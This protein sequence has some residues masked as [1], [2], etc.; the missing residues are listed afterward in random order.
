MADNKKRSLKGRNTAKSFRNIDNQLRRKIED[1]IT[2]K[3]L[4]EVA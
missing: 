4:T 1:G 2:S 3:K